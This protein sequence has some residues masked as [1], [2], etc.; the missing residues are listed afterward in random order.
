AR[1]IAG[2]CLFGKAVTRSP[3]AV[4]TAASRVA[5]SAPGAALALLRPLRIGPLQQVLGAGAAQMR[6]AILHHHLAIDV[7]GLVGNQEARQIGEFAVFAGATERI[8]V[9]PA[10]IAALGTELPRRARCRERTGRDR[11]GANALR[12]PLHG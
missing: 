5:C 1:W 3:T 11:D 2:K 7:A 4:S 10:F 8:A 9:R 6:A 12:A